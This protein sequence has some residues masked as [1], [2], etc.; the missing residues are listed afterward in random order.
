[1]NEEN[2]QNEHPISDKSAETR[3]TNPVSQSEQS[4]LEADPKEAAAIPSVETALQVE[5]NPSKSSNPSNEKAGRASLLNVFLVLSLA[6]LAV[7]AGLIL[8]FLLSSKLEAGDLPITPFLTIL[9]LIT[10]ALIFQTW[11]AFRWRQSLIKSGA[12]AL[13]PERWGHLI[14]SLTI[15]QSRSTRAHEEERRVIIESTETV[16]QLV[17][18]VM[19]FKSAIEE[20]DEEIKKLKAGYDL[21][22][23]KSY[24][25]KLIRLDQTLVEVLEERPEDQ[26]LKFVG[27][28]LIAILEDCNVEKKSPPLGSDVRDLSSIVDDNVKFEST[29]DPN[30]AHLISEVLLE[31]YVFDPEGVNQT[32]KPAKVRVYRYEGNEELD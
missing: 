10:L 31:A 17:D 4:G 24:L 20:R 7:C 19:T 8:F 3:Q 21:G 25:V 13:V 29:T 14:Q 32:I 27:R 11:T 1:M 5:D 22:I 12:V 28:S 2:E 30:Q 23:L 26:D 9:G 16:N 15:E 6:T 18:S